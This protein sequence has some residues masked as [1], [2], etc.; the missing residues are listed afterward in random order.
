MQLP[1]T[2][3][4]KGLIDGIEREIHDMSKE[5]NQAMEDAEKSTSTEELE[6]NL[7]R[8]EGLATGIRE[9]SQDR[10]NVI[11]EALDRLKSS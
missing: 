10:E 5:F 3:N 6:R 8:A 4:E 11:R 7:R 2:N 1:L 9:R